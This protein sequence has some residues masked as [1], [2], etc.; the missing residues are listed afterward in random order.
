MCP[1]KL[2]ELSIV[3][4][5][6]GDEL[7]VVDC[8]FSRRRQTNKKK[9]AQFLREGRRAEARQCLQMSVDITHTMALKLM[10]VCFCR[11]WVDEMCLQLAYCIGAV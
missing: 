5:S 9:A 4:N 8:I 2:Y 1:K 6:A 10:E 11:L 7:I 3:P